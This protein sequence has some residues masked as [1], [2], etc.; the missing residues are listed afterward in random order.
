M[1]RF[2]PK[3]INRLMKRLIDSQKNRQATRIAQTEGHI[4]SVHQSVEYLCFNGVWLVVVEIQQFEFSYGIEF[5]EYARVS[6]VE[7][8]RKSEIA[9]TLFKINLEKIIQFSQDSYEQQCLLWT[10]VETGKKIM[11]FPSGNPDSR[12]WK[13]S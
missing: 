9:T 2:V 11:F 4:N 10:Y 7:Q 13:I 12:N 6:T 3:K 5:A 8:N 1:N